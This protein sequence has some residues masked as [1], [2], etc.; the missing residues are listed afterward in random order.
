M[1]E[2]TIKEQEAALKES[3]DVLSRKKADLEKESAELREVLKNRYQAES[4]IMKARWAEIERREAALEPDAVE[5]EDYFKEQKATIERNR[6][7]QIVE[8]ARLA[9]KEA[10]LATLQKTLLDKSYADMGNIQKSQALKKEAQ[11]QE[12]AAREELRKASDIL[13]DVTRKKISLDAMEE[14]LRVRTEKCADDE[15]R[16]AESLEA[17]RSQQIR[18]EIEQGKALDAMKAAE[19]RQAQ[20]NVIQDGINSQNQVIKDMGNELK[21]Q[22]LK[23]AKDKVE[24]ENMKHLF[25]DKLAALDKREALLNKKQ[26]D[27]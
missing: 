2:L 1:S 3:V 24:V 20:L 15:K 25:Q 26:G 8:Q 23:I 14:N 16:I 11:E 12:L 10:R 4:D 7:M 18:A 5:K 27:K 19:K 13:R 6:D 9:E 21:E 17:S 22:A